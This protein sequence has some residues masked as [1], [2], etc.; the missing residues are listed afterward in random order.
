M[1]YTGYSGVPAAKIDGILG[2]LGIRAEIDGILGY[3]VSEPFRSIQPGGETMSVHYCIVGE[4]TLG[5][6]VS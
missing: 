6:G 1:G 5:L 2:Y 3:I 4:N